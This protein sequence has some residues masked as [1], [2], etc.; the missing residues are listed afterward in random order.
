M[1]SAVSNSLTAE[2]EKISKMDTR[3][4]GS[5][6]WA[7]RLSWTWQPVHGSGVK[8]KS[9]TG[10]A[11]SWPAGGRSGSDGETDVT[12]DKLEGHSLTLNLT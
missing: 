4:H 6:S 8:L 9:R 5:R 3:T 2:W 12:I 10:V 1:D 11:Y 7:V